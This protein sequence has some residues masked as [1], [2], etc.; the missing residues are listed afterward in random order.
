[1]ER[2]PKQP[3]WSVIQVRCLTDWQR[4]EK[5]NKEKEV[6]LNAKAGCSTSSPQSLCRCRLLSHSWFAQLLETNTPA[7]KR[8]ISS[9]LSRTAAA[10]RV[11][12]CSLSPRL[13]LNKYYDP[14]GTSSAACISSVCVNSAMYFSNIKP[15]YH[16]ARFDLKLRIR[17]NA[18]TTQ[19]DDSVIISHFFSDSVAWVCCCSTFLNLCYNG[20]NSRLL[21]I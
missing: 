14:V 17:S 21:N 10:V 3:S 18:S 13:R 19:L 5:R 2:L 8:V 16:Q 15:I 7:W 20:T 6:H 11:E 12:F 1:M 9:L 4:E